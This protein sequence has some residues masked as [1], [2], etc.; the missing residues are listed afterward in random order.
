MFYDELALKK[1]IVNFNIGNPEK[2]Q[3]PINSDQESQDVIIQVGHVLQVGF[4]KINCN[5]PHW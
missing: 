4:G 2:T 1:W 5:F 3:I